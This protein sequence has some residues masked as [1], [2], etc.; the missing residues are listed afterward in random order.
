MG[1]L[2]ILQSGRHLAIVAPLWVQ[3]ALL[4]GAFRTPFTLKSLVTGC[5]NLEKSV[6]ISE[7][8]FLELNGVGGYIYSS[9][10]WLGRRCFPQRCPAK[11]TNKELS[12]IPSSTHQ[13]CAL[14]PGCVCLFLTHPEKRHE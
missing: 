2:Q 9:H 6:Y 14:C 10:E 13:P 11:K 7:P 12:A 8:P 1:F 5:V 3:S 4:E